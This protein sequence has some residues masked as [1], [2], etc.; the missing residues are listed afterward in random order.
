MINFKSNVVTFED[1][2]VVAITRSGN[3]TEV[4]KTVTALKDELGVPVVG[5]TCVE[6]SELVIIADLCLKMPWAFDESVCQ[7]GIV[8]NLYVAA[9]LML[10][11]FADSGIFYDDIKKITAI[12]DNFIRKYEPALKEIANKHWDKAVV[13]ADGEISGLACEAAL[14]FEEICGTSSN[15]YH[16]LDVRHGPMV[17]ID[18]NTLVLA[19][20]KPDNKEHQLELIED[21]AKKGATIVVCTDDSYKTIKNIALHVQ[22]PNVGNIAEGLPFIIVAQLIAYSK[23]I[24]KGLDPGNPEGLE[25]FI[26]L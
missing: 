17:L 13:L 5:I 3:T 1:S 8:T 12:G 2:I 25:A 18:K 9:A 21:V 19:D 23:A 4:L 24:L 10:A 20:L 16:V 15:Y 22:H 6:D 11:G 26:K 7:T 14:A